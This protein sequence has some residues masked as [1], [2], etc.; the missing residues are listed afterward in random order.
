VFSGAFGIAENVAAD[1]IAF[2]QVKSAATQKTLDEYVQK[3]NDRRDRYARMI[4]AVHSS[5]HALN[6]P[7]DSSIQ[8]W[9]VDRLAELVVRLGL[10]EWI[11]RK[12]A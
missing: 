2:V 7:D 11:E 3:F 5:D 9:P 8:V 4:F 10:A 1:E 12:V 6:A